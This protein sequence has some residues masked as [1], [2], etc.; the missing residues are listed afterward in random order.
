MLSKRA[1]APT[2]A[3]RKGVAFCV[4]FPEKESPSHTKVFFQH[5]FTTTEAVTYNLVNVDVPQG[6]A[7]QGT[8]EGQAYKVRLVLIGPWKM[9]RPL[10]SN[11]TNHEAN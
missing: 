6:T 8:T 1:T 10:D 3:L 11:L 2:G 9:A 4:L 5:P 7:N